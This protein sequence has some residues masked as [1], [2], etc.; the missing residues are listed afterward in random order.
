ML[1]AMLKQKRKPEEKARQHS[2]NQCKLEL[3]QLFRKHEITVPEA[4]MIFEE[5]KFQAIAGA[6]NAAAAHK[7][8]EQTRQMY[9]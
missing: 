9:R 5:I 2:V 7:A 4:I 6:L 1:I 8:D 3:M